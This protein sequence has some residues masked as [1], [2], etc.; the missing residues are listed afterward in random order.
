MSCVPQWLRR[1]WCIKSFSKVKQNNIALL[2]MIKV[3]SKI[4]EGDAQLLMAQLLIPPILQFFLSPSINLR[5]LTTLLFDE[6][7]LYETFLTLGLFRLLFCRTCD[8]AVLFLYCLGVYRTATLRPA[9][10]DFSG[11]DELRFGFRAH[12]SINGDCVRVMDFQSI[13]LIFAYHKS[14]STKELIIGKEITQLFCK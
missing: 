11:S 4:F 10:R 12:I 2:A 14:F 8:Q 6:K 9:V 1:R 3:F 5:P 13:F 7:M